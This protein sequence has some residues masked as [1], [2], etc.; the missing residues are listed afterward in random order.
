MPTRLPSCVIQVIAILYRAELMQKN[1]SLENAR[2]RPLRVEFTGVAVVYL[3]LTSPLQNQPPN[4]GKPHVF[5]PT[6]SP[7]PILTR[8]HWADCK[9]FSGVLVIAHA[10]MFVVLVAQAF[11]VFVHW[12]SVVEAPDALRSLDRAASFRM[13]ID[14]DAEEAELEERNAG[15]SH[16]SAHG[17]GGL[18]NSL[19][20]TPSSTEGVESA[21][22]A[23]DHSGG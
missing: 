22:S 10:T 6:N 13:S 1:L 20:L 5:V 17:V 18:E 21:S 8:I 19:E 14:V 4:E 15:K 2:S 7:S 11:L 9:V 12:E 23:A 3:L 16:Q